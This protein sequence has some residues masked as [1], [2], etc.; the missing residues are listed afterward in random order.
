[1]MISEKAKNIKPSAT[2]EINKKAK[3]LKAKGVD[4]INLSVGEPDFDTPDIIKEFA[5]KSIKDGFTKYTD[6]AGI[7]ELREAICEKLEKENGLSYAPSQ[8]VV[9]NGAK[10][11]LYNIFLAILNDG[12]EVI[13]PAPYWVSYPEMVSLAG[14]VP[15]FCKWDKNFKIDMEH[16]K[17]LINKRTKALVLNSPSN[18]TG[19]VYD[20]EEIDSIA[21]ILL[22]NNI[23]C[24]SDEVYEKIM[25]DGKQH[26]SIASYSPEMKK[27]TVV[28]N[29]VSKTFAMTGWRIGYIAAEKEIADAIN[30]IQGQTT[31]APS[32]I[33][34]KA[35]VIAI[36]E[37]ERLYTDMVKEFQKRRD[38]LLKSIPEE[39][40]YPVPMG[41]FYLFCSYK[42][43]DSMVLCKRLLEEKFL[44]AVPGVE[45]GADK[46]IRISYATSMK[47]LE[48]TVERLKEFVKENR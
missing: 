19:I 39:F 33:S 3:E 9:S 46:F 5:I 29:A 16:L 8:I 48:V 44:A 40:S 12:D 2:L 42:E 4:V 41:A 15:V 23:I 14:G 37:G 21:E 10:H 43:M 45:F 20:K 27:I 47:N 32:S 38:Y 22:K 13:I 1:M 36:K 25:Y 34:Q 26:I 18:P 24:I 31:S 17:S 28:V 30:K 35:A 6:T 11:S 7:L